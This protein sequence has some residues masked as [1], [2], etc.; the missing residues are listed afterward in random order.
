MIP[1]F[2]WLPVSWGNTPDIIL[3]VIMLASCAALVIQPFSRRNLIILYSAYLLLLV[4]DIDRLQPW[5]YLYLLMLSPLLFCGRN[6]TVC[7]LFLCRLILSSVYFWSGLQK[8][9]VQFAENIFPWLLDFTGGKA[10][11]EIHTTYA[12]IAALSEL[13]MGIMLWIK[14]LRKYA[15]FAVFIM[16]LLILVTLGPLVHNWNIVIWPWN[17]ALGLMVYVL[18]YRSA[19]MKINLSKLVFPAKIYVISTVLLA[20]VM[21]FFGLMG[22]WDH[23]L[24]YGFYSGMP[25]IPEFYLPMAERGLLPASSINSQYLSDDKKTCYLQID[26]WA[27]DEMNVP[28]YPEERIYFE[29][30]KKLAVETVHDK[31]NT[32]LDIT[33]KARF[34][35]ADKLT[36]Y[37]FQQY[38]K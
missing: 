8:L 15:C 7:T 35:D 13:S 18:F 20:S 24:S 37:S 14:P 28:L 29:V 9:N 11:L 21:P 27:M 16:H 10:Y 32:G 4:E 25:A 19:P 1:I 6:K 26:T 5:L 31:T 2:K 36:Y 23:F 17:I 38:P 22:K 3:F 30:A 12:Y 33:S 34:N